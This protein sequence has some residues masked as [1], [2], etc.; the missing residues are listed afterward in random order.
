MASPPGQRE[1][2]RGGRCVCVRPLEPESHREEPGGHGEPQT[3]ISALT[4]GRRRRGD[5]Q[6]CRTKPAV[7]SVTSSETAPAGMS[8]LS[9]GC[10]LSLQPVRS[11]ETPRADAEL[12]PPLA[13]PPSA[14]GPP[15]PRWSLEH[16][17][18]TG[19]LQPDTLRRRESTC[20]PG[21][22]RD[23]DFGRCVPAPSSSLLSL[24]PRSELQCVSSGA[25]L[26]SWPLSV[27][28][29]AVLK[30]CF[31]PQINLFIPAREP[32]CVQRGLAGIL[33]AVSGFILGSSSCFPPLFLPLRRWAE[34]H[35]E[36]DAPF[37]GS[38][39]N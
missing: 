31:S 28:S 7:S 10:P 9:P 8:S 16:L 3:R 15:Q 19:A 35:T 32:V 20:G 22:V 29:S 39:S 37:V 34:F 25:R 13:S 33:A 2:R 24:C 18:G 12:T 14:S 23:R 11:P 36:E 38:I 17:P 30:S 4:A 27:A 5:G 21:V 6:L 26:D 1:L